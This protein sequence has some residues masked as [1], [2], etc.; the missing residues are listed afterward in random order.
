M[1]KDITHYYFLILFMLLFLLGCNDEKTPFVEPLNKPSLEYLA[2]N[3]DFIGVIE[4]LDI[5]EGKSKKWNTANIAT[6][7]VIQ[8]IKGDK[9]DVLTV[10]NIPYIKAKDSVFN[11]TI[12]RNGT[13]LSFL[14]KKD[15]ESINYQPLTGSSLLSVFNRK[16]QPIWK[17]ENNSNINKE[18][19]DLNLVLGKILF[20]QLKSESPGDEKGTPIKL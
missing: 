18:G 8:V 9:H 13:Y 20:L 17:E 11:L 19:T 1:V 6:A 2:M 3:S 10:E 4:V 16:V 12:L 7:K 15:K 14:K 5:P